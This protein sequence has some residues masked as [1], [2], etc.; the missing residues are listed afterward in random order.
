MFAHMCGLIGFLHNNAETKYN[1]I[2]MEISMQIDANFSCLIKKSRDIN[3][4]VSKKL[5]KIVG[6]CYLSRDCSQSMF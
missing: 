6:H 4:F 3:T 5:K 1:R 2:W